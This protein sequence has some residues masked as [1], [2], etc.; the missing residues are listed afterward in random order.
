M[1]NEQLAREIAQKLEA[2]AVRATVAERRRI[3]ALVKA[4][5]GEKLA[6]ELK[7]FPGLEPLLAA[8][9][10]WGKRPDTDKAN[11]YDAIRAKA[12]QPRPGEHPD[13]DI[14][15]EQRLR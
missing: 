7:K 2:S 8:L 9:D 1:T 12:A 11:Q 13:L 14:P 10:G 5:G 6:A 4:P 15:M 3:A